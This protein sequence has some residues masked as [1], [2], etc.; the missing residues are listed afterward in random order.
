MRVRFG[1]R[2][3]VLA[4]NVGDRICTC[5]KDETMVSSPVLHKC[6]GFVV[7]QSV[8]EAVPMPEYETEILLRQPLFSAFILNLSC[9]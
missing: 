4:G 5:C 9:S 7:V 1:P 8:Q 3:A 2:K 6:L